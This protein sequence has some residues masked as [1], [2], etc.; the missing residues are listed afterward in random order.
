MSDNKLFGRSCSAIGR[1]LL[2][3]AV[4][5]AA[6]V[7]AGQSA[8]TDISVTSLS[9]QDMINRIAGQIPMLMRMVTAFGYV[10]GMY[11]IFVSLMKFKEFGEQRT[12][13]SAQHH[14]KEPLTYLI[15]GG[16]LLYLPSSVQVGMSTFWA[17]PSPY[18][19]LEGE[20]QWQ[21]FMNNCFLV[22]QLFGT[23]AFIRGLVILSHTGGQGGGGQGHFAKG[24][25]HVIGGIFCINIYQFIK[26]ILFTLGIQT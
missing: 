18:G 5:F 7:F 1:L 4:L 20:D 22:I 19:Y 2:I 12:M 13:M 15:M 23:I 14:L 10:I 26:V 6:P 3:A 25:T 11:F 9:A 21:Q 8:G 17:D 24:V 16:L